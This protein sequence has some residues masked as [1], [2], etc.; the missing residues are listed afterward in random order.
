MF[1]RKNRSFVRR[2]KSESNQPFN[3]LPSVH[4]GGGHVSVWGCMSAD[5]R[6][7]LVIYSGIVNGPAY[8]KIIEEALQ[9]FIENSFDSSH[10]QW[11][12]M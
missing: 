3:F 7:P 12:F 4:G 8:I 5:A 9:T 6:D 2:L 10:K 1:I 11:V